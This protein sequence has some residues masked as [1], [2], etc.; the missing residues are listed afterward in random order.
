M[1]IV[2][3]RYFVVPLAHAS[4]RNCDRNSLPVL[5]YITILLYLACLP[6][7]GADFAHLH[8][9]GSVNVLENSNN[10]N[11]VT[12]LGN[13]SI[14]KFMH[15]HEILRLTHGYGLHRI[16]YYLKIN[17][18]HGGGGVFVSIYKMQS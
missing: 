16:T 4:S 14:P 17:G 9:F 7:F 2:H 11:I 6:R 5:S 13:S 12:Q 10:I 1:S 18:G 3:G 15:G 8:F